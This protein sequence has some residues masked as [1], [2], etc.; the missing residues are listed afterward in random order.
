M[1]SYWTDLDGNVL[2]PIR[3]HEVG[4]LH[5]LWREHSDIRLGE[6]RPDRSASD[7][8]I[9]LFGLNDPPEPPA[10]TSTPAS[11]VR[12]TGPGSSAS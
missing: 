2:G 9:N 5:R 3:G 4:E 11:G 6:F 10:A 7:N 8:V 1:E 12:R